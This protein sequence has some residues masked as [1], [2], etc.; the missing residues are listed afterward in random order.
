MLFGY[1]AYRRLGRG[2]QMLAS[3]GALINIFEKV[4]YLHLGISL[5][6]QDQGAARTLASLH[7][8]FKIN[9]LNLIL[10]FQNLNYFY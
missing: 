7:M 3:E 4:L 2:H 5:K 9:P 10:Y 8:S 6:M 1:I